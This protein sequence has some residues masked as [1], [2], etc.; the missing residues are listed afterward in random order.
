MVLSLQHEALALGCSHKSMMSGTVLVCSRFRNHLLSTCNN[1]IEQIVHHHNAVQLDMCDTLSYYSFRRHTPSLHHNAIPCEFFASL[2]TCTVCG[3]NDWTMKCTCCNATF[4][5][6]CMGFVLYQVQPDM[7]S[8]SVPQTSNC[9][10]CRDLEMHNRDAT[11][12][13]YSR[14]S[15]PKPSGDYMRRRLNF[16]KKFGSHDNSLLHWTIVVNVERMTGSL[17]V[18][19]ATHQ[20]DAAAWVASST[21]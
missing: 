18:P 2:A 12:M 19:P 1:Q 15:E 14:V 6:C 11:M 5:C 21:I 7:Q 10:L 4:R 20:R 13:Y 8:S 9:H 16:K 3:R 17:N